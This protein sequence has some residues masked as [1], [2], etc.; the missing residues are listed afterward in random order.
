[1]I[2]RG[3]SLLSRSA[4]FFTVLFALTA[5]GGGGGNGAAFVPNSLQLRITV[6]KDSVPVNT[7]EAFAQPSSAFVS[8]IAVRVTENDSS[9]PVPGSTVTISFSGAQIGGLLS[10]GDLF[11]GEGVPRPSVTTSTGPNGEAFLYFVSG[12]LSGEATLRVA[13][14]AEGGRS[15]ETSTTIRVLSTAGPAAALEFTGPFIEA[16]RTNRVEFGLAPGE[17]FDFQNGTYSRVVSVTATDANGN[18][19][20]TNTPIIFRLIDAPLAGYPESGSG[21]FIITGFNGDAVEGNFGFGANG[22][23]F[24][25]LGARL[26]D[27]LVL[28]PDPDGRSFY[29]E[30]IRTIAELP[31]AQPDVLVI[32]T[33]GE[34]F[35]VG[36]DQGDT[37]PYTIGRARIGSIQS[38]AFTDADG[39]ASTLLT[40]PYSNLGRTAIL[41]AQTED[42]SVSRVFNPGGTVYAGSLEEVGLTLSAST[43]ILQSNVDNGTVTLC[44]RD[45]NQVP[46]PAYPVQFN[47][48]DTQGASVDVS[49]Q[50]TSGSLI[51][52]GGGC[53][54][55][56]VNVE[57][58]FPGSEPI[59]LTFAI[60]SIGSEDPEQV[61]AVVTLLAPD[62]GNLIGTLNCSAR[63]LGLLYLTSTGEP[64]ADA[65]ISASDFDWPLGS[66]NFIFSP[67]SSG[68]SEAGMTDD[69]GAVSVDF[70]IGLPAAEEDDETYTYSA[71]FTTGNG[72]STFDLACEFTVPGTGPPASPPL[73]ITTS[74]VPAADAGVPYSDLL[75][76]TGGATPHSWTLVDDD[77]A[78]G[79]TVT[80]VG[81][82]SADLEW[83]APV[84]GSYDLVIRVIDDDGDVAQRT[85]TLLV[86]P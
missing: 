74:S 71:T 79:L 86:N 2:I 35:R 11:S 76:S 4:A 80:D 60:S 45:G 69:G 67:P 68:G 85:L 20:A 1:M 30:G 50:G 48:G 38:L 3:A 56:V 37:V 24:S 46:L 17:T 57:N 49:G 36:E 75:E 21:S 8:Q 66:P 22:G 23:S 14:L 53:V 59:E 83:A 25:A 64:I 41:V 34:P 82:T 32:A 84:A 39:V 19:V 13:A 15:E 61:R 70:T 51:T 62:S 9:N 81:A 12:A 42:Y 47:T 10:E 27:R 18:P 52:G 54:T 58:Q 43:D 63:T 55:A 29:H 44:V 28:D 31:P 26:G 78:A 7:A 73:V 6:E 33:D 77:G 72:D 65:L 16:I 40:Y 5:C